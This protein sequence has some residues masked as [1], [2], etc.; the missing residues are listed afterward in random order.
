MVVSR[1]P[2]TIK[3]SVLAM[4]WLTK[5]PSREL[6][7]VSQESGLKMELQVLGKGLTYLESSL[8]L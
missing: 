8:S 4:T 2:T 1:V 5:N 6:M 3:G 7:G